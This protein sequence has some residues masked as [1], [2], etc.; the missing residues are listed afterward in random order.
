MGYIIAWLLG[1]P[2]GVGAF[3]SCIGACYG[4]RSKESHVVK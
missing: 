3:S 2:V 4:M 1:I